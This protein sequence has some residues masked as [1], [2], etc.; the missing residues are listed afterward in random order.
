[1]ARIMVV[2]DEEDVVYLVKKL[3]T[4]HNHEV[5]TALSARE[6]L[7]KLDSGYRPELI[8]LDV[9]MPGMDGWELS[10][11]IKEK[12]DNIKIAMFTVRAEDEDKLKS[13]E[14]AKADWHISKPF[15]KEDLIRTVEW[16][17]AKGLKREE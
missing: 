17:L 7:D 1:M 5:E 11:I 13:L 10:K 8:L 9:M 6:A 14:Q 12:Y 16:L 3:L 15:K 2:D 4:Q